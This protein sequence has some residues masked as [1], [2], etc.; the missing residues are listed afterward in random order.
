MEAPRRFE[1]H[2]NSECSGSSQSKASG[3][4]KTVAASSKDTPCFFRLL[5]AFWHPKR[6]HFCI[7]TNSSGRA[8]YFAASGRARCIVPLHKKR[9]QR[10][11]LGVLGGHDAGIFAQLE[12][13]LR[14]FERVRRPSALG[15]AGDVAGASHPACGTGPGNDACAARKG[16]GRGWNF[17]GSALCGSQVGHADAES[18]LSGSDQRNRFV[19]ASLQDSVIDADQLS[20][21]LRGARPVANTR[22]KCDRAGLAGAG[23]PLLLPGRHGNRQKAHT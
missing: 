6:T 20:R 4:L 18:W 2:S 12:P 22:R 14:R 16:G 13:D 15:A 7:Y 17:G 8:S 5:R 9:Q 19:R 21:L 23:H 1:R 3:S 10:Y 11:S